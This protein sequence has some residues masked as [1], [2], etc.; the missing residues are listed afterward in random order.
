MTTKVSYR[1]YADLL[2][3]FDESKAAPEKIPSLFFN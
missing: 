3:T 1:N 2:K